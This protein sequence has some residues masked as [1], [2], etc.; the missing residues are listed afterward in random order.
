ME[1]AARPELARLVTDLD[2]RRA[3]V[4]EVELVLLVVVVV[5]ALVARRHDDRVDAERLDPERLA[6][7]AKAVS[8]AELVERAECVVVWHAATLSPHR[9]LTVV[10]RPFKPRWVEHR[11]GQ[12]P[13]LHPLLAVA[14]AG[15]AGAALALGGAYAV[16]S[17]DG[18]ST[19]T[20]REVTVENTS[21]PTTFR[22]GQALTIGEIYKRSAPASCRSPPPNANAE[23]LRRLGVAARA[24]GSGF[25]FDK[26]GYIITNYHVIEGAGSIQVTFSNNQSIDATLVGSDP[27][28]D[29]AVL[30]VN[31]TR[32]RAHG[33]H[34]RRFR[35]RSRWATPSSP[36][37]TRS[38]SRGR[39]PRES[40]ARCSAR[41]TRRTS[42]RSTTSS[43]PTPPINH[44]NS[45]GPLLNARG[46]VIGVNAQ[47]ET[48]GITE[49]NVGVGFAV[50]SNTVKT[51]AGQLIETGKVE[52]A[53]IGILAQPITPDVA[54]AFR[55]PV[56]KGVLVEE[57][58]SGSGAAKAGLKAGTTEVTVAGESYTLG[59]DIIVSANGMP[60]DDLA[61]LRDVVSEL[62]P[63]DTITLEVYRGESKVTIEVKLGRRP[64][65]PSG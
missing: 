14:A 45:G 9:R 58:Q 55:L 31:A 12:I 39:S 34:A 32:E 63:G 61:S 57:V 6:Y 64:S 59:G 36:S 29:I 42:T 52:H 7:L 65:T 38:A 19:V 23:S 16:G 26:A 1:D 48:G 17:L 44:G 43:R 25:V 49:G 46:E 33:A 10:K 60:V 3:R 54:E 41:S 30:K 27:S 8:L 2:A 13:S 21:Q 56:K 4:D 51:V 37:A 11:H 15:A 20:V 5:E 53:A 62:E 47:I 50:P 18:A 35:S 40:S 22:P 28:T 24:L